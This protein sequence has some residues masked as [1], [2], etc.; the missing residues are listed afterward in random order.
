MDNQEFD[1]LAGR[2]EG[3]AQAVL[4]LAAML[5]MQGVIDGP[6]LSNRLRDA[7]PHRNA[8]TEL[9]Q[10]ARRTLQDLVLALDDAR[11]ARQARGD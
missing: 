10:A 6:L 8:D 11:S 4:Q 9:R 5:E 7:I 3:V 2:I 1:E